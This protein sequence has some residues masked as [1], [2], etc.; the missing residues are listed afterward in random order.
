M[1]CAFLSLTLVAAGVEEL[2][3]ETFQDFIKAN[4]HVLVKFTAPWCGHCKKI[5]PEFD[6]AAEALEAEGL[7]A[8]LADV[9][10][11]EQ[12]ELATEFDVTGYPTLKYF[13]EGKA[14]DYGGG[15]EKA[16]FVSFLK[17]RELPVLGLIKDEEYDA[18]M[19]EPTSTNTVLG[20]LKTGSARFKIL[21]KIAEK[22]R[23]EKQ[24]S[25]GFFYKELPAD[26]DPKKDTKLDLVSKNRGET[27]TFKGTKFVESQV[28]KFLVEE[29]TGLI[30]KYEHYEDNQDFLMNNGYENGIFFAF[31]KKEDAKDFDADKE[32]LMKELEGVAKQFKTTKFIY[33]TVEEAKEKDTHKDWKI[34][35]DSVMFTRKHSHQIFNYKKT[36][37]KDLKKY[38]EDVN[39]RKVKPYYKS[40][41]ITSPEENGV[42][43]LNGENFEEIALDPKKDVFVEFYAPWCGHC[44]ALAPKWEALAKMIKDKGLDKKVIIAKFDATANDSRQE[45]S[46]FP[47][48]V[49]FPAVQRSFERK[50]SNGGDRETDKLYDFLVENAKH[51]EGIEAEEASKTEK[52]KYSMVDRELEKK[53]AAKKTE[54]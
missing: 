15:R 14:Q 18:K 41:P 8:R 52:K 32:K 40:E 43:V 49:L 21:R 30:M 28:F 29:S 44:K 25:F 10:A 24:T 50:V 22:M 4:E 17:G 31:Q 35:N 1:F 46:G 39:A 53:K 12:K 27:F 19:K 42:T 7:K 37:L 26:K 13:H 2:T 48:L 34:T 36:D 45:T 9:D 33:A 5:K 11:T 20:I 3:Q 23:D 47:T 51:M 38:I 16:D 54:L 6:D